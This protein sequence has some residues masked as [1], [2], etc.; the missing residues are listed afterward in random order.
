MDIYIFFILASCLSVYLSTQKRNDLLF[1]IGLLPIALFAGFRYKIGIDF[2]AYWEI[3]LHANDYLT[4][5]GHRLVCKVLSE[6]G[7]GPQMHYLLYS[8][9]T[10]IFICKLLSSYMPKYSVLI[11]LFFFV[12]DFFASLNIMRQYIA[13]VFFL[14]AIRYVKTHS[15]YKYCLFILLGAAFHYS[16]IFL[17]PF[18]WLLKLRLPPM[19][20][21]LFLGIFLVLSYMLPAKSLFVHIPKYGEYIAMAVN[22]SAGLGMGFI[23][24]LFILCFLLI[25]RDRILHKNSDNIIVING[26]FYSI[27]LALLFKDFIV[28]LRLAYYFQI[29]F[30][31][32]ICILLDIV[33]KK[34]RMLLF[35]IVIA[36]AFLLLDTACTEDAKMLPY[37][38]NFDVFET[39]ILTD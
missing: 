38:W 29:F 2:I 16:V 19:R 31:V 28:F 37:Q 22:E 32:A 5:P 24:R 4:E 1:V 18:Y 34:S 27:C 36:Y 20:L 23:S 12:G 7:F 15:L 10:V 25:F 8:L 9:F 3:Y 26:C 30:P 11:C 14:Y 39:R 6:I 17:F 33:T 13:L 35:P 21:F